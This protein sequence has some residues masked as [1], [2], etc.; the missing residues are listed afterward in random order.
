MRREFQLPERDVEFLDASGRDWET[1][2]QGAQAGGWLL[3]HRFPISQGYNQ[4]EVIVALQITPSYDTTE[5]DMAYVFPAL[6]R[7]DGKGIPNLTFTAIDGRQFQ[8]W[9][10]HRS[11]NN[12]WRPGVDYVGTHLGLVESWF[13]REFTVRP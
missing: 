8:R 4:P 3:I 6:S 13:E 9:S 1:L 11:G 2:G 7:T 5:I 10:R 12:R